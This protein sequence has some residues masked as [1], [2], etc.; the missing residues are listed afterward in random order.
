MI[1]NTGFLKCKCYINSHHTGITNVLNGIWYYPKENIFNINIYER[2][3]YSIGMEF[4]IGNLNISCLCWIFSSRQWHIWKVKSTSHLRENA[5]VVLKI[6]CMP[7]SFNTLKCH[8]NDIIINNILPI[9]K[10]VWNHS[11][12][13]TM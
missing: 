13:Y 7:L 10:L 1:T 8:I 6:W 11:L 5:W 2:F 4:D 12:T 9:Y 3:E